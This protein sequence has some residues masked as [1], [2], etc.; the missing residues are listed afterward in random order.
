LLQHPDDATDEERTAMEYHN[1]WHPF[2][3]STQKAISPE[4]KYIDPLPSKS[5]V[6]DLGIPPQIDRKIIRFVNFWND[7]LHPEYRDANRVSYLGKVAADV[8]KAPADILQALGR[9]GAMP[10]VVVPR[11]A[12]ETAWQRSMSLDGVPRVKIDHVDTPYL[13]ENPDPYEVTPE[14]RLDALY[15]PGQTHSRYSEAGPPMLEKF[16]IEFRKLWL[17]VPE[18]PN[19][20]QNSKIDSN[21]VDRQSPF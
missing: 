10:S 11:A 16:K 21:F 15:S 17:E 1:S 3:H 9:V 18:R 20:S 12:G 8:S 4:G 7:R 5:H 14:H 19:R 6:Q 2:E 13:V